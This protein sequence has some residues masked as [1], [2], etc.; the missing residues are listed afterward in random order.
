MIIGPSSQQAGHRLYVYL[1][2]EELTKI[3]QFRNGIR[4]GTRQA[5]VLQAQV[6]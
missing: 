4:E 5:I 2:E 6:I 1:E 3:G